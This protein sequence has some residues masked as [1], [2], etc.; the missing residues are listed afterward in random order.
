MQY[1][2]QNHSPA[3]N[4]RCSWFGDCHF[5]CWMQPSCWTQPSCWVQ[6]SLPLLSPSWAAPGPFS[7]YQVWQ[8]S[9]W[10]LQIAS[11]C[12]SLTAQQVQTPWEPHG[13]WRALLHLLESASSAVSALQ[14]MRF[15]LNITACKLE[16][17]AVHMLPLYEF[18]WLV[19]QS[20]I[21]HSREGHIEC[22]MWCD[23][24]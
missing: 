23:V 5:F 22:V 13:L 2:L 24:V 11:S 9:L 3:A 21:T 20:G 8:L 12:P 15:R 18:V 4:P 17:S 16:I 14:Q 6:A 7:P 1:S 19:L 10:Q